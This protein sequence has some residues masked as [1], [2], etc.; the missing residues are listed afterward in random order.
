M[1]SLSLNERH[2]PLPSSFYNRSTPLVAQEL[3]GKILVRRIDDVTLLGRI[4]ETEAYLGVGDF[5]AHGAK[6]RTK[7]TEILFGKAGL[8]YIYQLRSYYLLNVVTEEEDMP[9]AVLFRALEPLNGVEYLKHT[10]GTPSQKANHLLNGPGKICRA[11]G[12]DL[13]HYGTDLTAMTSS[14][15]VAQGSDEPFEIATSTRIGI[16]KSIDLPLRFTIKGSR[17][18]SR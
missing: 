5:A 2:Q 12:I 11:F 7:R 15:Y 14:I 13:T 18:V 6:R 1:V 9:S 8:A 17:Y 16:T 10:L 4:V 3:L